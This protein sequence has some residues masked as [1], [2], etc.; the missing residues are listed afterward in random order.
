[1]LEVEVTA[2]ALAQI[3]AAATWWARQRPAAP[4]AVGVDFEHAMAL[5]ASQPGIGARS[6]ATLYP[7]L[8]R[9]YLPRIRYHVYYDLRPGKVVIL[10]F[11]HASR[12]SAPSF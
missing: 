7:H 3:E 10:A 5:L 9:L 6:R 11:W 4:D 12:G 1:V 2:R 8:R